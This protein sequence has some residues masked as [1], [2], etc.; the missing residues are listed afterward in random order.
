MFLKIMGLPTPTHTFTTFYRSARAQREVQLVFILPCMR[1]E[2]IITDMAENPGFNGSF[3]SR[4]LGPSHANKL[5]RENSKV[6]NIQ[7]YN[8]FTDTLPNGQRQPPRPKLPRPPSR[9]NRQPRAEA[10]VAVAATVATACS[11]KSGAWTQQRAPLLIS[12]AFTGV[13]EV[14]GE[15]A[16]ILRRCACARFDSPSPGGIFVAFFLGQLAKSRPESPIIKK[17]SQN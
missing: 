5:F 7:E 14:Q 16:A 9:P 17:K 15:L 4:Q 10:A 1:T 6:R 3:G 8:I 11:V 2:G 12:R 13:A